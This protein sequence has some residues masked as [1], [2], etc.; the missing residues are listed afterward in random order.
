MRFWLDRGV[1]G[2][3]MDAP[4]SYIEDPLFRDEPLLNLNN[5]K[6]EYKW[7]ELNH[8][9]TRDLPE[10]YEV[11]HELR[12]FNDEINAMK[13]GAERYEYKTI[14]LKP[15]FYNCK[16]LVETSCTYSSPYP[17][18]SLYLFFRPFS[19]RLLPLIIKL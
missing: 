6:D 2:L 3:R 4:R 1:S 5:K 17:P 18:L 10:S 12:L 19:I 16:S 9:Y 7:Y 15:S 14:Y 13:G 11:I 8:I